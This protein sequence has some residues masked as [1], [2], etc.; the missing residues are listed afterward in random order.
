MSDILEELR[1]CVSILKDED[2]F[3]ID[4]ETTGLDPK[5][6][7]IIGIALGSHKS[8][9]QWYFKTVGDKSMPLVVLKDTLSPVFLDG[10]KLAVFHNAKFDLKM[11]M[12]HDWPFYCRIG[13][14]MILAY[15]LDD[16]RAGTGRLALKGKG[17]L[18]D[19]LFDIELGTWEESALAGGLFGKD[20]TIYAKQDV[21]YT[22]KC[23]YKLHSGLSRQGLDKLF[24]EIDMP[25]V[26]ILAEMELTGIKVDVNYLA[27]YKK[28]LQDKLDQIE[29]EVL[30][31][32]GKPIKIG[33]PEQ[34]SKYLFDDLDGPKL[35]PKHGMVRGKNG[36]YSTSEGL[37]SKY[38]QECNIVSGVLGWRGVKKLLSTYVEPFLEIASKDPDGRIYTQFLQTRTLTGRFA[39]KDPNLQNIPR[40]SKGD[41]YSM[42]GAFIVPDGKKMIVAD[43]SQLELRLMA[44]RSQDSSMLEIY[45]NNGDIHSNTQN[46]LGLAPEDR[47]IAKGVNFG[48]LYGMSAQG[49]QRTLWDSARQARTL[50]ECQRWRLGFFRAYPGI[51]RYHSIVADNL[52]KCGY[53]KTLF[54]RRRRVYEDMKRDFEHAYRMALNCTIQGSAADIVKLAMR[55][56][57]RSIKRNSMKDKRWEDVKMLLQVHDEIVVEAPEEIATDVSLQLKHDMENAVKLSIPLTAEPKIGNSWVECK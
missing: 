15:T 34:L 51:V 35:E 24:Y 36:L 4:L 49:L 6:D 18:V 29:K 19:E 39:S 23:W 57:D 5:Y 21:E 53:T 12:T 13:D 8:N 27:D 26:R 37:L 50:E 30:A 16:N 7:K 28:S 11:L 1:E 32:V 43:Y 33:S 38:D 56:F 9:K 22:L 10:S 2:V 25:I 47:V 17:G 3:G 54:N 14:S 55:D 45:K 46:A 48:L 40:P 31:L 44:H 52:K 20:E 41:K 42:R